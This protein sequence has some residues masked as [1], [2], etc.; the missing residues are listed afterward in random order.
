MFFVLLKY[1]KVILFN[2]DLAFFARACHIENSFAFLKVTS[3]VKP[4]HRCLL[5]HA[6]KT[7]VKVCEKTKLKVSQT[8]NQK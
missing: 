2:N 6:K 5:R 1:Q 4:I 8:Y 7:F 3:L